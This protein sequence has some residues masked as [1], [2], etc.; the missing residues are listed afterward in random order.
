MAA[1]PPPSPPLSQLGA[2][3]AAATVP[4]PTIDRNSVALRCVG[5]EGMYNAVALFDRRGVMRSGWKA[6][7]SL[8]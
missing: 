6:G 2:V 1:A 3:T 8:F 7:I 4:S 5:T